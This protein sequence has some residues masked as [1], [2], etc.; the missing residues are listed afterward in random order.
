MKRVLIIPTNGLGYEGIT[1]VIQN[2]LTH[3]DLTELSIDILT[4][5]NTPGVLYHNFSKFAKVH[6]VPN[7]KKRVWEYIIHLDK[8]MRREYDILHVHGNSGTMMI[9]TLLARK[10][11]IKKIIV[12]CHANKCNHMILNVVMREIMKL[13]ATDFLACSR[14]AGNWLYGKAF[15]TI[16]NNAIDVDKFQYNEST[17]KKVRQELKLQDE[18]LI[19]HIGHFTPPKNHFFLIDIFKAYHDINSNSKMLL[20]GEGVDFD[21][22]M[23]KVKRDGLE[24]SVI[25]MGRRND[26]DRLYQAMDLFL[27]PS[28]WESLGI[29]TLEAQAAGLPCLVSDVVPTET[30]CSNRIFYQSLEST[31]QIWASLINE[32]VLHNYNRHTGIP[33]K[34]KEKGFDI[35]EESK[36][37]KDLYL[38]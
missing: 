22:V 15:Y 32:I 29:V 33:E 17:R 24:D 10:N 27:L 16:I 34:I 12:H 18:V 3:M 26:C 23:K 13:T 9:E 36:K 7:R 35:F 21:K 37:V 8:L 38:N 28:K 2:Y 25:F 30:M 1:S 14:T 19:G 31:P 5:E 11:H 4:Y 6:I 20:V